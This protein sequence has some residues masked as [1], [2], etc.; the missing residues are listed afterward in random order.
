MHCRERRTDRPFSNG[1]KTGFSKTNY[2]SPDGDTVRI[3]ALVRV[4]S[5]LTAHY[6][7][8]SASASS[9]SRTKV[10]LVAAVCVSCIGCVVKFIG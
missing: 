6:R 2:L 7:L 5:F 4:S 3:Q 10:A 9:S 8:L 1:A